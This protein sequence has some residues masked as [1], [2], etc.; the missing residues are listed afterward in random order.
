L[1]AKTRRRVSVVLAAV[2][3][4]A[5]VGTVA[6]SRRSQ[7]QSPPPH[8]LRIRATPDAAEFLGDPQVRAELARHDLDLRLDVTSHAA[9]AATSVSP[10]TDVVVTSQSSDTAALQRQYRP[11][12]PT[13][14]STT[15]L[16]IVAR[17]HLL[18]KLSTMQIA[19][20]RGG[21]WTVDT[22]RM[23]AARSTAGV[24]VTADADRS[25]ASALF[26]ALA[27]YVENGRRVLADQGDVDRVVN[28]VGPLFVNEGA[29]ASSSRVLLG[30]MVAGRLPSASMVVTC[31]NDVVE[32]ARHRRIP[33]FGVM[34]PDPDVV[35]ARSM[36]PLTSTGADAVSL[37]A[38]DAV[39]QRLA[40]E[41]G[42]GTA[43]PTGLRTVALPPFDTLHALTTT[44]TAMQR[45]AA[46]KG[47]S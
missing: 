46:A 11:S 3:G 1:E 5:V 23:L 6:V 7:P 20:D 17:T 42:S 4:F 43:P 15:A 33:G 22:G 37:F 27:G 26:A 36:I 2:L 38:H 9:V 24:P 32:Q 18:T 40:A 19:H 41:Y 30:D 39:L 44:L 25:G 12:G 21:F 34:Y 31:E 16:V 28:A 29:T 14:T 45:A 35:A 13:L 10:D 47:T 8:A